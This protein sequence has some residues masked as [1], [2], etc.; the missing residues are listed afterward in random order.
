MMPKDLSGQNLR[1]KSFKGQDLTGV[2]FSEADIRG[3]NFKKTKLER[4][5]FSKAKGGITYLSV[6][7]QTLIHFIFGGFSGFLLA[8][9]GGYIGLMV[10]ALIRRG[11][12]ATPQANIVV[13]VVG[14]L[15]I[16]LVSIVILFIRQGRAIAA[17]VVVDVAVMAIG[18]FFIGSL[19]ISILAEG[20][21]ITVED[22][23]STMALIIAVIVLAIVMGVV[24]VV[25]AVAVAVSMTTAMAV[26][27][28]VAVVAVGSGAMVAV[29]I[30]RL[31]VN[32]PVP[33]K[34]VIVV[35][36]AVG[37]V[38]MMIIALYLGWRIYHEDP[39]FAS[40][41]RFAIAFASI[42]GTNF[43]NANLIGANFTETELKNTRFSN[44]IVM[45]T[46][47][48]YAKNLSFARLNGT[49]LT[50]Q[51]VRKLLITGDGQGQSFVG[52]DLQGAYLAK[53]NLCNADLR[54]VTLVNATFTQA[55]I[56]GARLYGTAKEGWII[57]GIICDYVYWDEAGE[58]R[59]PKDREFRPGEF[60]EL[61]K[62][63][64]TFDYYFKYGFTALDAVVMSR[65][66]ETINEKYPEFELKLDSFHSRG[67]PH[68]KFTVLHKEDVETAKNHV[69]TDYESRIAALEG[70]QEQLMEIVSTLINK[71]QYIGRDY[72]AISEKA[73]VNQLTTG[74]SKDE[75][76][77]EK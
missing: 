55:N 43:Q 6:V 10:Y 64:P 2:N 37:T 74:E 50:D 3:A 58:E 40:L 52:K 21:E 61:Y 65:I 7:I 9:I 15:S 63:L 46:N 13:I 59:A 30:L 27:M 71:P 70:K 77:R 51:D 57:D 44:A 69:T 28:G 8:F 73:Q 23:T 5:D 17:A 35:V 54:E 32:I 45:H 14:V 38:D 31:L 29:N 47:W 53:V 16:L 24:V 12:I 20:F 42:Y 62:Q 41:R 72:I 34:L 67:L 39:Q 25:V 11:D 18:I 4:A 66:V 33:S 60:E 26:G 76:T 49:I 22:M 19:L 68:A 48:R 1:G 36:A 75:V 56:T